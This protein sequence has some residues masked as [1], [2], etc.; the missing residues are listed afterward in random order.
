MRKI[1]QWI[2]RY[3]QCQSGVTLMEVLIVIAVMGVAMI[4]A[5]R[6]LMS[7]FQT[8][9]NENDNMER[10]YNAQTTL[11]IITDKIR[12]NGNSQSKKITLK[13]ESIG[14]ES[15]FALKIGN[16]YIYYDSSQS[17]VISYKNAQKF[18][19]L[20][21]VSSFNFDNIEMVE[22]NKVKYLSQFDIDLVISKKDLGNEAFSTTIYL[23]NR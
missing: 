12:F 2:R 11:E 5:S 3:L 1:N 15:F 17:A 18:I 19:L 21:N 13:D 20:E 6:T 10:V 22:I 9:I 16:E 8:F 7:G 4:P 23:R 14:G